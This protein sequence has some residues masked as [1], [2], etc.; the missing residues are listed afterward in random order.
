MVY[1]VMV[2]ALRVLGL[3]W[4]GLGS[5]SAYLGTFLMGRPS[6]GGQSW[7]TGGVFGQRPV[8]I[9]VVAGTHRFEARRKARD[10]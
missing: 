1:C 6:L 8:V 5:L 3:A 4:E 9:H 2:S 7:K 10:Q